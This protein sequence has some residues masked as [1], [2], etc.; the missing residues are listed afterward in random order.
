MAIDAAPSAKDVASVAEF[1][2]ALR[3]FQHQTEI[4]ARECGITPG[5]YMLLLQ[6]KGAPDLTERTTVTALAERMQL[7]QSSVTELVGRA[8]HA[9]LVERSP[10]S[11][12]ARVVHLRLSRQGEKILARAFRSLASERQALRDAIAGLET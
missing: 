4:V 10:S 2:I 6:I 12:D 11:D 9:G 7:A 1:R 5:W 8:Q 3:R